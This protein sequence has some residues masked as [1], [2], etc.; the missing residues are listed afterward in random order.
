MAGNPLNAALWSDA[1]V[2][3]GD[4]SATVPTD[5]DTVFGAEWDLVGLISP[6]GLS[7]ARTEEEA[8]HFAFGGGLVRTSRRNFKQTVAFTAL[9]WNDTTRELVWPGS[10]EDVL[11]VPRPARVKIAFE[12][13]E[14]DKVDRLISYHQAEVNAGDW[15]ETDASLVGYP[16]TATIYPD[17]ERRLFHHQATT[18]ESP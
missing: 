8:D 4:L 5:V 10:T 9:E 2:Y 3:V 18:E 7:F 1:D 6:D 13:R 14:G 12:R 17:G 15:T 11:L 16:L